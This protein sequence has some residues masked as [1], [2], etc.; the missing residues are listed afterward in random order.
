M[1]Y[2][3]L[4][5]LSKEQAFLYKV[6]LILW[7]QHVIRLGALLDGISNGIRGPKKPDPFVSH[8]VV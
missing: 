2:L 7:I 3:L 1:Y 5:E 6:Q 4:E 8:A